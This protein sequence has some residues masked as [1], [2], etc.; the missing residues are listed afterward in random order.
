MVVSHKIDWE[1]LLR[2]A[3]LHCVTPRF[4]ALAGRLPSALVPAAFRERL[5]DICRQNLVNQF[6][7]VEEFIRIRDLLGAA[8]IG[9]IPFKGFWLAQEAY[10]NIAGR[11]SLDVDVFTYGSDLE[12]IKEL[13]TG[14]GYS[15]EPGY[16]GKTM[17]VIR[18]E[19][20]EYTF[21][22]IE[23][24]VSAFRIEFHWG[25]CPPEY[26]MNVRLEDLSDQVVPGSFQGR[27]LEVFTPSAQLLLTLLHHGGKDRFTLL[28]QVDDIAMITRNC[29]DIDWTWLRSRLR[30]FHAEPLLYTGV[31]LAAEIAGSEIPPEIRDQVSSAR[32]GRLAA[33]R[34]QQMSM[35]PHLWYKGL[36][37]FRNWLFRMRSRTGLSTRIKLTIATAMVLVSRRIRG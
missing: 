13:M 19:Y 36:F 23:G 32:T 10:G 4:A 16:H 26:L 25:I 35:P 3:V 8:G 37:N 21:E 28:K 22:K 17:A 5:D 29:T 14:S 9:I 1:E 12:R 20:Q 34:L 24:G 7:Y 11:E 6:R 18:T 2:R 33:E 15:E 31:R 30:H 27:D